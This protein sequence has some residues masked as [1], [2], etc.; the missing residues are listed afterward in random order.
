MELEDIISSRKV[1]AQR[2]AWKARNDE[3]LFATAAIKIEDIVIEGLKLRMTALRKR[4]DE[5]VTFQLEYHPNKGAK[6]GALTRIEWRPLKP[7]NNKGIGPKELQHVS[8]TGT[9]HHPF[10]LNWA[11]SPNAVRK[12]DLPIAVPI[13]G[14]DHVQWNCCRGG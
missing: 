7:H 5:S 14:V 1:L 12:G 4:P 13:D 8:Q 6:G 11:H 10:D 9:H 3:W 2:P